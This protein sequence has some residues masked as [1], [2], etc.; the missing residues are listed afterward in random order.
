[1]KKILSFFAA[2]LV[3]IAVNAQTDFAAPGYS[4]AADDAVLSGSATAAPSATPQASKLCLVTAEPPYLAWKDVSTSTP[5]NAVAIWSV[6]ATRGCYVSVTLDLS[7]VIIDSNKHIFEVKIKD[8]NGNVK[9]TLAEPAENADAGQQKTLD[10][11]ILLPTAGVYTV[12][13]RNNRSYGKGAV[14]NVILTYAADAPS[15][16]IDVASV[17]L[18]KTAVTLDL[19]EVE[20]LEATVSPDN[21]TDPTVTWETSDAAVATVNE[22]GLILAVAAGTATITA[23][24]GEQS[25]TCAVTVAAAAIPDVNFNEPYVLAGK[26]AH[27]E[28]AIWKNEAYK[29]YGD[30]GHNQ[31]YGNALWTINVT[32]PCVVSGALNGV[33][34][35]HLFEL[36]LYKGEEFVTTIAHS[37]DK[38]WSAGEIALEGTLTFAEAGTY[39]LKLRNTQE[40][41]SGKVASVTLTFVEDYVPAEPKTLYCRAA[42]DWW[43][44]DVGEQRDG[45]A[46]YAWADGVP[47]NA[48]W[49]GVMMTAVEGEEDLYTIELD[50]KYTMVIFTRVSATGEHKCIKTA[51]LVIPAENN[52]YTITRE[53]FDWSSTDPNKCDLSESD[54]EWSLYVPATYTLED[55]FYLVGKFGGVDAW[56]IE[57]LS[58]EKKYEWNAHIGEG[59]EEW[60][61]VADL[62]AGDKVKACYVYHDAITAYFPDGEGNEYVVDEN[63]AGA[64]KTIYF[65]QMYNSDWGGQFYIEPNAGSAIHN[66]AVDATAVKMM[67]NGQLVIIKNGVKYNVLGTAL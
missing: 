18:N 32:R 64:G 59:N 43:K 14:L 8:A 4:C 28:G 63:H 66:A 58:A 11:T 38:K 9:G 39:T 5:D 42:K 50:A 46:A 1:M 7:S 36:D 49:P 26:V 12:E 67:E 54:G 20:L 21:A 52:L 6:T 34:G 22:N 16:I 29:L 35:G 24:A 10:G 30:G 17:E 53:S 37:E 15:E 41:S 57:S 56:N 65:Q 25:A 45:V 27:L 47:A 33:E 44:Y 51:D 55:G 62:V 3:A 13:L 31:H 23:T 2:A 48:E 60:K 19:Q 40:W 61:V